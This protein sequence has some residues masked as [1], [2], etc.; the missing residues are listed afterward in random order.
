MT[1]YIKS[2][3]NGKPVCIFCGKE[4]NKVFNKEKEMWENKCPCLDDPL[5]SSDTYSYYIGAKELLANQQKEVNEL[6]NRLKEIGLYT[7]KDL[8]KQYAIQRDA[9]NKQLDEEIQ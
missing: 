3:L 8:H 2:P 1:P 9:I 4:I 5:K 7:Y 6:E